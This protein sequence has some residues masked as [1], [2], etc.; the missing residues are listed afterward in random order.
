MNFQLRPMTAEEYDAWVPNA[1]AEYAADHVRMGSRPAEGALESA[2]KE[3][4][5]L[6]PD[7]LD[8]AAHHLLVGVDDGAP[9]GIL[10]L[11]IPVDQ[12]GPRAFVYG[13]EVDASMRG[14]GYGRS[15][16][17]AA[18]SYAREHGATSIRL[19]VFGDNTVARRLYESLG[20]ETTNVNMAKPL[21]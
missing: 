3:F 8:T 17:L 16:M 20:Y 12:P 15:I 9:V 6:L 21:T 5:T 11:N 13:V 14:R 4:E 10:W 7:G 18:E 1:I 19:H 2:T